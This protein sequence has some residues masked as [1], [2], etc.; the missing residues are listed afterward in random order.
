M[1][2][3][4]EPLGDADALGRMLARLAGTIDERAAASEDSSYTAQLLARG[5]AK[6]AKKIIEEGGELGLALVSEGDEAV[7][8]EAAD[9]LYHIMVGLRSRGVS[10]DAVAGVLAGREGVSGLDEKAGRKG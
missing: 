6:L 4:T 5:P 10:L 8:S 7:A 2:D 9:L 1:T 3:P